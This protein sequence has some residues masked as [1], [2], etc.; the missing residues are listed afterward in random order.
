M[1]EVKIGGRKRKFSFGVDVLGW[2]QKDS[3]LDLT[4]VTENDGMSLFYI[5][6]VPLIYRAHIREVKKE[7]AEVDF[8]RE[9][10][11]E[12]VKDAGMTSE[13]VLAIW[14]EFNN[15]VASYLPKQ[16]ETDD[17]PKKK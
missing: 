7:N 5:M 6:I 8:T 12:W 2:V 16:E 9:D 4:D 17:K 3:G 14:S 13:A 15:S 1:V 11:E 10:V